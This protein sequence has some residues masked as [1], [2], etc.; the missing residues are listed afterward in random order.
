MAATGADTSYRPDIYRARGGKSMVVKA[1]A[2]MTFFGGCSI[3]NGGSWGITAGGSGS[4]GT[5]ATMTLS[6]NQTVAAGAQLN[7]TTGSR[8]KQ[9]LRTATSSETMTAAQ[10]GLV[11]LNGAAGNIYTLPASTS[12]G[13]GIQYTFVAAT[14]G[15]ATAGAV[16]MKVKPQAADTIHGGS[17]A[18]M[19]DGDVATLQGATDDAGD[20]LRVISDGSIGWFIN[21]KEGTWVRT[22][23]T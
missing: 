23:A 9:A 16:G 10:S 18:S 22:T 12:V 19:T 14:A 21:G 6:G 20:Y 2:T 7:F 15:L 17:I 1:T 11:V 3:G 8:L 5:G 13:D 4:V